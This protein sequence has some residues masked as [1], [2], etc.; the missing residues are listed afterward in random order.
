MVA[1]SLKLFLVLD[2]ES[3]CSSIHVLVSRASGVIASL[4]VMKTS[5][6]MVLSIAVCTAPVS[7]TMTTPGDSLVSVEMDSLR[8]AQTSVSGVCT[9]NSPMEVGRAPVWASRGILES[10]PTRRLPRPERVHGG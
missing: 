2:Q 1:V 10:F 9:T 6:W 3:K 5:Y 4:P 8:T 7:T